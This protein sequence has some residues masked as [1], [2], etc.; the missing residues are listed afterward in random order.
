[1]PVITPQQFPQLTRRVRAKWAPLLLA[2]IMGSP[3]RLVI[4]VA[5]VSDEGFHIETANALRRLKCLYGEDADT[6]IFTA[7]AAM[8]ALRVDITGRGVKALLEPVV[9]FSGVLVGPVNDGEATT[10]QQIARVWMTSL[11]S[12]YQE[13]MGSR[14]ELLREEA[15][16]QADGGGFTDRL[17]SLVLKYVADRRPGLEAFFNEDIRETRPRRRKRPKPH[18]VIIDFA[19]SRLVANFGTLVAANRVPSVD[20][21]KRRIFDLIVGRDTEAKSMAPRSRE[22]I[23]QHPAADDPQVGARQSSEIAEAL[24]ALSYQA[25]TENIAFVPMTTVPLIGDH[26]LRAEYRALG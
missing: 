21:I 1:M 14:I 5:A 6:A 20:K 8:D 13:E 7:E 17:P 24:Q 22:M 23:V 12:L 19:G 11:S 25:G 18:G 3:E 4:G 15:T 9:T 10:V 26:I 2:P 16:Q